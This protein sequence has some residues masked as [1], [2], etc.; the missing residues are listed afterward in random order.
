MDANFERPTFAA[1]A[2][3][4]KVRSRRVNHA[5]AILKESDEP[6]EHAV[7]YRLMK[8]KKRLTVSAHR[9]GHTTFPFIWR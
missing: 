4:A 6:K 7:G 8:S 5:S 9:T 1:R 2:R 3:E